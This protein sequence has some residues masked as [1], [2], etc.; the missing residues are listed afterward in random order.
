MKAYP[1]VYLSP[2]Y[3]DAALSCGGAIHRLVEAGE[4]V[5]VITICAAPPPSAQPFSPFAEKLHAIWGSPADVIATRQAE[6]QA[7]MKILGVDYLHLNFT[8]CIYRGPTN[9]WYYTSD[10]HL[11]GQIHPGDFS[12]SSDIVQAI[13]DLLPYSSD[14]TLYAPLAAGDHI[15]HQLTRVVAGQLQRQGN[16][17]ITYYEDYP[18][19]DPD[20]PFAAELPHTNT[21]EAALASLSV[22]HLQPQLLP[23]SEKNLAVKIDSIC[24]YASQLP[25]LFGG[26]SNVAGYVRHYALRV[27]VDRPAERIWQPPSPTAKV[28][29]R[30]K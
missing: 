16:W 8:D 13:T 30:D 23:L 12:L 6:D 29:K 9:D 18:Y 25:M 21:L 22:Q 7:A 4:P 5:L 14:T 28:T 15:D 11:F 24:A 17:G 2:H 20:C 3:D 10:P 19:V 27:G 1:H 26:A